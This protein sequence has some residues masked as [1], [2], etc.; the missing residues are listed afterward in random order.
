MMIKCLLHKC[1]DWIPELYQICK[2][3]R[4]GGLLAIPMLEWKVDGGVPQGKIDYNLVSS[5]L[6]KRPC[7]T[8]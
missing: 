1:D 6:R 4:Y 8:N 2:A 3:R 5:G 7:Q